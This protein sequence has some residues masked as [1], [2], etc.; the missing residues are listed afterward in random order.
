MNALKVRSKSC[1]FSLFWKKAIVYNPVPVQNRVGLQYPAASLTLTIFTMLFVASPQL[2]PQT[3]LLSSFT[4]DWSFTRL[5]LLI[6][7]N[8]TL[9]YYIVSTDHQGRTTTLKYPAYK[10]CHSATSHSPAPFYQWLLFLLAWCPNRYSVQ[11]KGIGV[12][13]LL[14]LMLHVWRLS[15]IKRPFTY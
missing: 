12:S 13:D 11:T 8:Q 15:V 3:L 7:H 4:V 1:V 5:E 6:I 10:G 9:L 2:H 14:A